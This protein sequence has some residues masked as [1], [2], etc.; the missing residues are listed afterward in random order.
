MKRSFKE[1]I[2]L[3]GLNYSREI[4]IIFSLNFLLLAIG[5]VAYYF[6]KEIII[7]FVAVILL[8]ALN[9]VYFSRYSS[10]EKKQEKERVDE[11][12]SLLSYFEIYISNKHNVYNAFKMLL[13]YCS[14]FMEGAINDLLNQIDMDKS[15]GPFITFASKFTNRVVES[16]MLSIY[17]MVDNGGDEHQFD[18][19]NML[20]STVS[21]E[22]HH[23]LIDAK[24]RSL[25]QLNS[26]P[27]FGAGAIII[28]LTMC[29][30]SVIGDM[31]NVL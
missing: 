15:V 18:E 20:F 13:P 17:Q 11:L 31:I 5:G 7:L 29:I 14:T 30:M 26:W 23:D 24:S 2:A 10:L 12:I 22:F 16:L 25:D 19:F 27:L 8:A 9:F 28:T 21:R 3:L 4:L 6:F 1:R